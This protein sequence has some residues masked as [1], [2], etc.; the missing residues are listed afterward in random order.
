M[1]TWVDFAAPVDSPEA[2][3][4]AVIVAVAPTGAPQIATTTPAALTVATA[5]L[6][7]LKTSREADRVWVEPS[8]P[9][10]VT[11]S[12][13]LALGSSVTLNGAR[14]ID[15][16]VGFGVATGLEDPPPPQAVSHSARSGKIGRPEGRYA[17]VMIV[18]HAPCERSGIWS[19]TTYSE[20]DG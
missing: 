13:A 18:A 8:L 3:S 5:V 15:A 2:E 4:V 16:S 19:G 17:V 1:V 10:P 12:A 7:E 6:E 14:A 11:V 9:V 20:P